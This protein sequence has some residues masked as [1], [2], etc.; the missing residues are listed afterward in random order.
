[1]AEVI[2]EGQSVRVV[3]V[4]GDTQASAPVIA[5]V[6]QALLEKPATEVVVEIPSETEAPDR[7]V[8]SE[9]IRLLDEEARVHGVPLRFNV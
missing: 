5:S 2:R 8:V 4:D 7:P 3:L 1:M 9:L 6:R